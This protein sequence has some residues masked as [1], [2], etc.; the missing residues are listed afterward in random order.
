MCPGCV[1]L[2]ILE[3][4]LHIRVLTECKA[5]N[6]PCYAEAC[7]HREEEWIMHGNPPLNNMEG[8]WWG[9]EYNIKVHDERREHE[10]PR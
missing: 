9:Q 4:P 10:T 1:G 2:G 5:V 7:Y 6:V 3:C 8:Y